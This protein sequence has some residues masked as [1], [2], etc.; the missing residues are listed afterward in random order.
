MCANGEEIAKLK[1]ENERLKLRLLILHEHTEI[2]KE[3]YELTCGVWDNIVISEDL[4][5]KIEVAIGISH[6]DTP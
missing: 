1:A 5:N 6:F 3:I 4:Y 2:L